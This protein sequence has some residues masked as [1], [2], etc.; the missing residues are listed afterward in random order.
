MLRLYRR[1]RQL[2]WW[3]ADNL[4]AITRMLSV[5]IPVLNEAGQLPDTLKPLQPLRQNHLE[6]ILVDGGS[7]D[8]GPARAASW[9]DII[10]HSPPGRARQMNQGAAR[11]RGDTLLFLHADTRLSSPAL[12]RLDTLHQAD[13][14]RFDVRFR[15]PDWRYR[16]IARLMNLRSR[17]T[18]IATGDQAIFVQ[19]RLFET[20]GGF[21]EQPLMEDIA[22][23]TRLKQHSPPLCL[24]E[25]VEP[26]A[27]Y[28]QKNGIIRSIITM[29]GLRAA[30]YF[31]ASPS[32]L[33]QIYY[34]TPKNRQ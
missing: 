28:W 14:G 23:S 27:R 3:F 15:E 19:R 2:L 4:A 21:P 6:I 18:G 12:E 25:T 26:S 20:I 5:I 9:C 33:K 10:L 11:A 8:D 31:G 30:Y 7:H 1:A 29:W 13:W 34:R 17:L 32:R 22:L 16:L 24:R